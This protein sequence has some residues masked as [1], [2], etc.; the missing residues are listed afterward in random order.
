MPQGRG[1]ASHATYWIS[2]RTIEI[3]ARL[4]TSALKGIRLHSVT[5]QRTVLGPD[6]L[7]VA[8][9]VGGLLTGTPV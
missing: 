1:G 6:A 7:R 2:E 8:S 5:L 9:R 3:G 4:D